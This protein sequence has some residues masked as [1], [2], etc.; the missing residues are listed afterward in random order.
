MSERLGE[1]LLKVG[2]L[3]RAQLD[4]VLQSQTIF[5]G[6]LGTNLVEMGVVDEEELSRVLSEQI[7][8]PCVEPAQ[9]E[10]IPK[11]VLGLV[12]LDLVQRHR[13]LPLSLDGK[14]LTVAMANPYDYKVVDEIGFVTGCVIVPRV[15]TELR[16]NRALEKFYRITR[17]TRFIK[18]EGGVR[19]RFEAATGETARVDT[20]GAGD[21]LGRTREPAPADRVDMKE[22]AER[23]AAAS[24]EGEVVQ[25]VLAYVAGEFD[26]GAFLRLKS[27]TAVGI[28]AVRNG[29]PVEGFAMYAGDLGRM[30]HLQRVMQERG[31]VLVDFAADDG[32]AEL[33]RAMG[34]RAPA[35]G[36]LVPVSLGGKVVAVI[37]AN[38]G[39]GRL[40]GGAFELQ[41][42]A[43]M[44]ELSFEMLS[45][46]KRIITA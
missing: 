6:R 40:G 24:G 10:S 35:P 16:L 32:E 30:P 34:G 39:S 43:V 22:V 19:T 9:L 46:R 13:V 4:Q 15:C 2:A 12:P 33:L 5:G 28:Q 37:C 44:A 42:V 7:G 17:P 14:R 20:A 23:M 31:L 1:M 45:L 3:T 38:D 29:V 8:A 26:R 36:L 11:Q 41:R 27:G 25:A 18:V 21:W